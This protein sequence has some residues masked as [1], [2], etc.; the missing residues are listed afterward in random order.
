MTPEDHIISDALNHASIIDG[1]R[2]SKAK[3]HVYPH[4][5]HSAAAEK[6]AAIEGMPGRKLLI[7]DGVFLY[8]WRHQSAPRTLRRR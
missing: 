3:I 5:D 1:A 6:L 2:L 7:T 8:G 4:K